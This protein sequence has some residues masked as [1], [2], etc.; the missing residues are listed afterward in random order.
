MNIYYLRQCNRFQISL[1]AQTKIE[2]GLIF[3][4]DGPIV[5]NPASIIGK[6][7]IIHP[8][9]LIGGSRKKNG[10]PQ[11][12]DNVFIGHGAKLIGPIKI[13][14]DVFISPGAVLTKNIA[15]DA[16]VGAGVNNILSESG[17]KAECALYQC[18]NLQ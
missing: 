11:I 7:C 16:V 5:I 1:G 3:P 18:F 10:S 15:D 9:V 12:G 17:G 8:C 4:H 2:P 6:N 14:N 13:G